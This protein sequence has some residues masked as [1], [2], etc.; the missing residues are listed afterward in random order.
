M[1]ELIRRVTVGRQKNSNV[2]NFR[3]GD[4]V[5]VSVK[6]KEGEKERTQVFRGTVIKVQGRG[7][8]RT[9]TVRK[10]SDG[11][12]VERTFPFFSPSVEKIKLVAKGEVRRARLYYLRNL[13]GK[14]ARITFN[15][16]SEVESQAATTNATAAGA[17]ASAPKA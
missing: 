2:E 4:T 6:V 11:V 12:G 16:V 1:M 9:F 5:E 3:S 8:S 10:I 14:K 15:L 13:K 7:A 17:E